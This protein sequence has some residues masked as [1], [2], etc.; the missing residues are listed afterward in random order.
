MTPIPK[1]CSLK[2][3]EL[4]IFASKGAN[5]TERINVTMGGGNLFSSSKKTEAAMS[6]IA[7]AAGHPTWRNFKSGFSAMDG[8]R[9]ADE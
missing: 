1:A 7:N 2:S 3:P 9:V 6:A 4:V 8:P 5:G